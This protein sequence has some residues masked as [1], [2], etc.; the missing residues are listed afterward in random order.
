MTSLKSGP[1]AR[2]AIQPLNRALSLVLDPLQ[3]FLTSW[4]VLDKSHDD[5]NGPNPVV[6]V[7]DL[8][9]DLYRDLG[10]DFS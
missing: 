8:I 7:A 5:P 10:S 9:H 4:D 3:Q 2:H 6:W 1:D